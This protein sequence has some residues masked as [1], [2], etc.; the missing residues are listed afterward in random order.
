MKL[1]DILT[2]A[3]KKSASDVHLKAGLVP[4]IRKHGKLRPL[5]NGL[6][7]LSS[8]E[9]EGMALEIMD[10]DQREEFA[11]TKEIDIGFGVSGL[12]RFRINVF[13][14]R[15]SVRMVIRNI[16]HTVPGLDELGLPETI[17]K[18]ADYERGLVLVTG[19]TG[20]GKSSTLAALVDHINNTQNSHI[21]TI[22]DPIEFLIRDRKSIVSQRELGHDTR[23]F[24]A[25]LRAALRQDPDVILI[26]EMRDRETI[27]IALT[28]AETGHLVLSTLHTKDAMETINRILGV[29]DADQREQVR[30]QLASVLKCVVSQRLARRKDK[31]GFVPA[32]EILVSN[33]RV[34]EMIEDPL[35]TGDLYAAIEE[36]RDTFGMQSFD[37]SLMDLLV[38][39][40]IDYD[41]ALKLTNNPEDFQLRAA[42][43]ASGAPQWH[44]D[45]GLN[46]RVRGD[47]EDATLQIEMDEDEDDKTGIR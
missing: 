24:S 4:V 20:S 40:L 15:G 34:R 29:F 46:R 21:L 10:P 38:R 42:G 28:A 35:K 25:A 12:G 45:S 23:S 6:T 39:D 14:Q 36:S 26:G 41:E 9:I 19:I 16:P 11:K 22:E 3:L 2:L 7:Q 13:R 1:I 43:V 31:M 17:K 30:H 5:Q 33:Q 44:E 18:I 47:L 27:E 37:Q 8:Q 32:V